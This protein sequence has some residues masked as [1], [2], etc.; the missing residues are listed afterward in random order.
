[1][2]AS[3]ARIIGGTS[4]FR[5]RRDEPGS[6]SAPERRGLRLYGHVR[7]LEVGPAAHAHGVVQLDQPPAG[8][9]LTAY[10][11]A[12]GAVQ[13]RADEPDHRHR[14]ADQEPQDE[15]GP[16]DLAH[17]PGGDAEPER[18]GEIDHR[19]RSAQRTPNTTAAS[20]TMANSVC[21]RP[22]TIAT[23][24]LKARIATAATMMKARTLRKRPEVVLMP[25][26][27]P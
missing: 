27:V 16:L 6:L 24:T 26:S 12:L 8:G 22:A 7:E 11:V 13:H 23:K 21:S 18:E 1:M 2:M 15:R 9:A 20:S 25:L 4:S 19:W 3:T 14:G 17:D 10:L 5:E